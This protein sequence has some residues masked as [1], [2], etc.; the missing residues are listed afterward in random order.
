MQCVCV[1]PKYNAVMWPPPKKKS[2][3]YEHAKK[4][5]LENLKHEEN[6]SIMTKEQHMRPKAHALVN[7]MLSSA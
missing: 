3:E 6:I 5:Y 4:R 7:F 2:H 1:P